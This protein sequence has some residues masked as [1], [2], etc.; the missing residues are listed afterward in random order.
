MTNLA[1]LASLEL[2]RLPHW[3]GANAAKA[4]LCA[5]DPMRHA[6]TTD[7]RTWSTFDVARQ[8]LEHGWYPHIGFVFSETPYVAI[9]LDKCRNPDTGPIETW[10]Q[11]VIELL[12]SYTD[13]SVSG[14]GVH[15][16]CR[17]VLPG[18][19]RRTGRIEMYDQTSPRHF[20]MTGRVIRDSVIEERSAQL[21]TLYQRTFGLSAPPLALPAGLD[22]RDA[23]LN[24]EFGPD[25][26]TR[27]VAHLSDDELIALA[28]AASNG[29]K[30]GRLWR[31]DISDYPSHSEADA[32]LCFM[33]AFWTQQDAARIDRLV[34]RSGLHR[35]KWGARRGRRTYGEQTIARAIG[36]SGD[37]YE[38]PAFVQPD[39]SEIAY[40]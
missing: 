6:S 19:R 10:A 18:E 15:I 25:D 36:R 31:G 37:I 8:G 11:D 39:A 34:R 14:R 24:A 38:P 17:G 3:I 16:I 12:N 4:P 9:D 33:L 23:A 7:R 2:S 28:H 29:A 22:P 20:V 35:S 26:L 27:S 30:F 5:F 32:A 1:A 13:E 21:E 40:E